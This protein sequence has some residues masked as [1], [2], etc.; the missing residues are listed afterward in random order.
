MSMPK[1]KVAPSTRNCCS[2]PRERRSDLWDRDHR[3]GLKLYVRRVFIMDDA[4]ELLPAYLRF[5]RG[6]VDANDLPLNVS[7]EI[8]Q[9]SRDVDTIRAGCAKRVLSL[10]EELSE[11]DAP[12]YATFW[13]AFG[14]VLKEGIV[15]DAG[16]RERVAKLLRF[17]ST[18][19]TEAAQDVSLADYITRMTPSQ[20]AI[21]YVTADSHA[22]AAGSPHLEIFKRKGLE[23]LLLSDR[24]DEWVVVVAR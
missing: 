6:V 20:D 4:Q 14:K 17:A 8:L 7:R 22:A 9:Q 13:A 18:R 24:V 19:S 11:K 15:E 23:V 5:V 16:N 1:S 21:W 3:H 12:K 2:S 10:L